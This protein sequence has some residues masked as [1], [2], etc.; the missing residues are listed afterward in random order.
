MN[1]AG[2]SFHIAGNRFAVAIRKEG[3][4][5]SI[6]QQPDGLHMQAGFSVAVVSVIPWAQLKPT[7]MMPCAEKEDVSL[8]EPNTLRLLRRF[9]FRRGDCL[10]RLQ[11]LDA[12]QAGDV[13]QH[14]A[15]DDP[16]RVSGNIL[17]RRPP[18]SHGAR[19]FTVIDLPL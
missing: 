10:S 15:A 19:R 8:A 2:N 18:G 9:Q 6:M 7:T 12:A 11:P 16:V 3:R 4:H 14:P 13:E 5:L 1:W 17:N